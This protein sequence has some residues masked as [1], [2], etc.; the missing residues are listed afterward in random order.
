MKR[1]LDLYWTEQWVGLR[2]CLSTMEQKNPQNSAKNPNKESQIFT[3]VMS[4]CDSHVN[5]NHNQLQSVS[6]WP[7]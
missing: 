2:A 4:Y 6:Y 7:N 3:S 1:A 5:R